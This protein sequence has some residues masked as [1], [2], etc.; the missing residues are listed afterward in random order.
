ME[1]T[2]G[3]EINPCMYVEMIF[4]K[5]AKTINLEK[6]SVLSKQFWVNWISKRKVGYNKKIN[7]TSSK[8]KTFVSKDTIN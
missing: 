5:Y 7:W 4:N 6:S 3:P 1:E 2:A 8:F